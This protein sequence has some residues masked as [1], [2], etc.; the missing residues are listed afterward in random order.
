MAE[1]HAYMFA[2]LV[3]IDDVSAWEEQISACDR[4]SAQQEIEDMLKQVLDTGEIEQIKGQAAVRIIAESLHS[5]GQDGTASSSVML[6]VVM[7]ALVMTQPPRLTQ[8]IADLANQLSTDLANQ[9][10]HLTLGE[11]LTCKLEQLV[12]SLVG[13]DGIAKLFDESMRTQL[14]TLA[15]GAGENPECLQIVH[16]LSRVSWRFVL[17]HGP[18]RL[19]EL[20]RDLTVGSDEAASCCMDDLIKLH[21][22]ILGEI[23][24]PGSGFNGICVT[25]TP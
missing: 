12:V 16:D 11:L 17:R 9:A 2:R 23:P 8:D 6:E 25:H 18:E 1:A 7:Q 24:I 3:G 13:H 14:A 10:D 15:V 22:A 21:G 19:C 5:F 20:I 4:E